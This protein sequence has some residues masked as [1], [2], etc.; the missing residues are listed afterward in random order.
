MNSDW[1]MTNDR[2]FDSEN[3]EIPLVATKKTSTHQ[4]KKS[5]LSN[6][7]IGAPSSKSSSNQGK[8]SPSNSI[9]LSTVTSNPSGN[10]QMTSNIDCG[11][12]ENEG[13]NKTFE[14]IF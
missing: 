12:N 2:N 4:K 10:L 5:N 1:T 14:T 13:F 8:T 11:G 3:E 9:L 7:L 6:I